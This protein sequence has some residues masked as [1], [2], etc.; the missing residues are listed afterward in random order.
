M[1]R[2]LIVLI[3]L[4]M[5]PLSARAEK[6]GQAGITVAAAA[7]VQFT[8]D[9]LKAEFTKE[10]GI[11][12]KSVIGSSGNLTSQIENGAPFDLFMSADVD[13]PKRLYKDGVTTGEPKIYAYGCLVLWSL[14][15]ADL[16]KGA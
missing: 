5:M 2:Y 8:L 15:D 11:T 14:K 4:C 3:F 9:E 13:Y 7:N 6:L 12:V 10:T 16:S 1:K